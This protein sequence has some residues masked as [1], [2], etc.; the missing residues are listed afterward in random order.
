MRRLLRCTFNGLAAFS[1]LLCLAAGGLWVRSYFAGD[2]WMGSD[3]VRVPTAG[4][5][6][7][8]REELWSW[9][10]KIRFVIDR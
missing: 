2:G 9:R 8:W 7:A 6:L 10:G 5:S 1:L 3:R 4:Y